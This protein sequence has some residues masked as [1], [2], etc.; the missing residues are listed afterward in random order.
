LPKQFIK[1][2]VKIDENLVEIFQQGSQAEQKNTPQKPCSGEF[3]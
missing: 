3:S 2:G 1:A